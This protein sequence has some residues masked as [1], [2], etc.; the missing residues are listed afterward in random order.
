MLASD[1]PFLER[2]QGSTV[3][4]VH[5]SNTDHRIWSDHAALIG[6]RHRV[7][8][9]TQRYFGT[10]PWPDDGQHFSIDGHAADL[11]NFLERLGASGVSLVGWSYGG[12]VCLAL[13]TRRPELVDRLLLY[14]PAIASFVED[15][16]AARAAADDRADMMAAAR[17]SVTGGRWEEAVRVFM[18]DV[19]DQKGAFAML[20]RRTQR[21]MFEN[22]PTLP[23]LF[24]AP[25][26]ALTCADIARLD[27]PMVVAVGERGRTFYSVAA[28][29]TTRC[30]PNAK[31]VRLAEARHL[32]PVQDVPL[33]SQLVTDLLDGGHPS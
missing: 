15:P 32:L 19:N 29:W 6:R 31:L 18:D 9:L 22:A 12:A 24:A 3:V 4:L 33:F 10:A 11:A 2:G 14:E 28:E 21:I 13:V 26:S 20:P 7:V 30:A 23:L 17:A 16:N 1:R 8:A 25:P 5:G 27:R